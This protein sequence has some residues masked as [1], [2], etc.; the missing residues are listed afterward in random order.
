MLIEKTKANLTR[1]IDII[2]DDAKICKDNTTTI[3]VVILGKEED[4]VE[5]WQFRDDNETIIRNGESYH[6]DL[7][8]VERSKNLLLYWCDE[9]EKCKRITIGAPA[10]EIVLCGDVWTSM[11]AGKWQKGDIGETYLFMAKMAL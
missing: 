4:T 11:K 8:R 6:L 1:I 5:E 2:D 9:G 10:M 3:T 7:N